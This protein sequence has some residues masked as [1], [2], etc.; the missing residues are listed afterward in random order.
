MSFSGASSLVQA[1]GAKAVEDATDG[2]MLSVVVAAGD[3]VS[4]LVETCSCSSIFVDGRR[5]S[6]SVNCVFVGIE[7]LGEGEVDG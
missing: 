5:V 6:A 7:G 2:S 1:M 3:R 4:C